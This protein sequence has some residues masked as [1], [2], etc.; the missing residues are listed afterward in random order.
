MAER[1]CPLENM[2]EI[3]ENPII[4][5]KCSRKKKVLVTGHQGYI[6]SVLTPLLLGRGHQVSGLDNGLFSTCL[7]YPIDEKN[8][9]HIRKDIRDVTREDVQGHDAII[10]LAGLSN[11]PLG[12]LDGALTKEIN[13]MA[14]VKIAQLAKQERVSRFLFSSSCSVY[15]VS[16]DDKP[17]A[18]NG[19]LNPV[20]QYAR[21]K[22]DSEGALRSL[23]S[24]DFSPVFLRN[25]TVYGVSPR[26]RVDLVVNNLT[27]WAHTTGRIRMMSDGSPWRP[28]IHVRDLCRAFIAALEAPRD[29]VHN[30]TFNVGRSR[31]NYRVRNIADIVGRAYPDCSVEYTGEH[32]ADTRTYQVDFSFFQKR[33]GVYAQMDMSVEKGVAQLKESYTAGGM[34]LTLFQGEKFIRLKW[35]KGLLDKGILDSKLYLR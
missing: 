14:T 6:G 30:Q 20:T 27:G 26:L 3:M 1:S 17:V 12:E 24:T 21:S 34:D 16:G 5:P 18:E 33:L 19:T 25:A 29:L 22:I 31:E 13:Y 23:A 15:G 8:I 10:H 9:R 4:G 32:G 2:E 35:I 11:D 28:L 7:L